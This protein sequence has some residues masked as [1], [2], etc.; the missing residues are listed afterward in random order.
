MIPYRVLVVDDSI[1]MRKIIS[2]LL[3]GNPR[4]KVVDTAVNGAEAVEKVKQ[5]KPDVVTMDVEMPVMD[6]LR[7]LQKIMAEHPTPV[8][9]LSSLT[10]EG[11]AATV[12]ALQS[13]AVDFI[14]KPSGSISLDLYKVKLEL[15]QKLMAAARSN[16]RPIGLPAQP[17]KKE[18]AV[19]A[20]KP[21][22]RPPFS[23]GT[24]N[25]EGPKAEGRRHFSHLVAIGTS[26]GGPRALQQVLSG[27]P[28]NF[29]APILIVQ[30]MPPVFTSSL[31]RRLDS[32]SAIRVVEA[33]DGMTVRSGTAYIAPGGYHLLLQREGA[34]QYRTRL[35]AE[36]T[37]SGHRPSVDVLFESL[38][39]FK[40]LKRHAVL[41]TGMGSDGAAGMLALK[42]AGAV[43]T[44]AEAEET[45][46]VYGMPRA[47]VERGAAIH[48]L[49]QQHISGKLVQL[50]E[51]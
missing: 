24:G 38:L 45:C 21:A 48:I 13:G 3:S 42:Q 46:V 6:G 44:I 1:F 14:G 35:S 7:A 50:I 41:M 17:D 30:H 12:K 16:V 32:S 4:L 51:T 34:D 43:T 20:T 10:Q 5:L 15:H 39:P 26:T 18:S 49:P 9:M 40:E 25:T 29:P 33:E 37:R 36:G 22:R 2:D 19:S 47:A 27:F 31:A 11:A 28:A 23:S 8:V